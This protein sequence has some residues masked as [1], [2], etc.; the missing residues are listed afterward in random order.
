MASSFSQSE[1]DALGMSD[2]KSDGDNG[3]NAMYARYR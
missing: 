2:L 1:L 3:G